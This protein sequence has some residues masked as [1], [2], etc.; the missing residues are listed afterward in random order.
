MTDNI[1]SYKLLCSGG[2][3]SNE[4][5]LDLSANKSGASTRLVNFDPSLYGG[6]RRSLRK[7]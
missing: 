2:L 1:E 3:N 7:H 5:H 4:T 6:Y